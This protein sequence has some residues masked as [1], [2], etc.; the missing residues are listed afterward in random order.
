MKILV[1]GAGG[2]I[3]SHL[4][5]Y[6]T[7][8]GHRVKAFV[9]Y[10]S[11]SS[12]GWLDKSGKKDDIETVS[13]DIR[14]MDGVR[15]A[16]G[17]ADAVFHLAALIGIP[18]SYESPLAYIKTNT[19]G[20]YNVLE[21]CRSLG[22]ARI[23]TASTSEIYGTA[24]YVPMD[25]RHPVNPRSPY[26]ASKSGADQLAIAYHRSF[27]TPVSVIR[28]FNT[29][30]P[31]QSARAVIPATASQILAGKREIRLG[32]LKPTRDLN[33][34][35]DTVKGFVKVGLHDASAG[36]ITNLG[37]GREISVGDLARKIAETAGA[38]VTIIPDE[39]RMRPE[40]SEVGRLCAD[41]SAARALGWAPEV[42]LEQGL[43]TTVE[44]IARNPECFKPDRYA[45]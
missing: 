31:R 26:A 19:E 44:W 13:G 45:T 33:F 22:V 16:A 3:G 8:L 4:A 37:S 20:T 32:N 23:V 35:T 6:L 36:K 43:R 30:G 29:Y 18:Y 39:S 5:E 28:P 12:R 1:T 17:G 34:V 24:Q 7:E 9:R 10:N 27:G 11:A 41:A 21:A 14:D 15:R 42:S 25:E 40:G 38:D 2:F